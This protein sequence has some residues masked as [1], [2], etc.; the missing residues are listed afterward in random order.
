L[1]TG[2]TKASV[3]AAPIAPVHGAPAIVYAAGPHPGARRRLGEVFMLIDDLDTPAVTV[4]LDKVARN[5]NRAADYFARHAI[6]LRPHIK[7][8]KITAFARQQIEAGACGITCQKLGEADIMAAA[9]ISDILLSF[10]IVGEA[11]LKRLARLAQEVRFSAVADSTEVADWLCAA[12]DLTGSPIGILVECDVGLRRCGVPSPEQA[13]ALAKHIAAR[14]PAAFAGLMTYPPKG[15]IGKTRAWLSE[16]L[17]GLE[18]CGLEAARVSVGGTPDMYRAHE[19]G[20][21]NE[22]RPGTYIYSDRFMVENGIGTFD[23]CAL[24]LIATVVSRPTGDRAIID[25][26]SKSLS[27]DLSGFADYGRIV[28]YPKARLATLSEEHG[29]IDLSQSPDK[30]RIGERLTL[31]PN[32]AC[33]VSNLFDTVEAISGREHVKTL[34]VDARG[35]VR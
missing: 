24:R 26:G 4:D 28:E 23:D 27:S 32:H 5:I 2:T 29:H 7:T 6:A 19:L 21:A 15:Q 18:A 9:G 35:M 22:H 16:A 17:A 25:A 30:P 8:H 33:V 12:T 3:R 14:K 1:V 34:R 11:K 20:V 31:I 13:V 10:P